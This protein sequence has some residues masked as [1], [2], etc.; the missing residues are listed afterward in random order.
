MERISRTVESSTPSMS[1]YAAMSEYQESDLRAMAVNSA[2]VGC[3][4]DAL[5]AAFVA[6]Y[7][8]GQAASKAASGD[9]RG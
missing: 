1:L 7:R 3:V 5:D 6:G 4:S 9:D 2:G 8:A